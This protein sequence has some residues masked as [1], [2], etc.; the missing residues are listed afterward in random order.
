[1]VAAVGRKESTW[2]LIVMLQSLG[3]CVCLSVVG[4]VEEIP[5][6]RSLIILMAYVKWLLSGCFFLFACM[7]LEKDLSAIRTNH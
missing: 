6:V 3:V 2:L 4:K 7:P 5:L 1:M